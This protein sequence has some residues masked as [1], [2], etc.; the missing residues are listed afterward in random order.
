[1]GGWP[2]IFPRTVSS[3]TKPETRASLASILSCANGLNDWLLTS[4]RCCTS[5]CYLATY[6]K[7]IFHHIN[8]VNLSRPAHNARILTFTIRT[9]QNSSFLLNTDQTHPNLPPS[10]PSSATIL[11]PLPPPLAFFD[12]SHCPDHHLCFISFYKPPSP[13]PAPSP[14]SQD[15]PCAPR[16][17]HST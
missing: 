9:S 16:T 7:P 13:S 1:M 14:S 8:S 12:V 5:I 11:S 17:S 2:C 4:L 6:I 10:S 15:P 3:K